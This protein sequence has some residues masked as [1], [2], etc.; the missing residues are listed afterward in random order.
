MEMMLPVGA[1]AGELPAW[2]LVVEGMPDFL[3]N[4]LQR[5]FASGRVQREGRPLA[6]VDKVRGGDTVVVDV[7]EGSLPNI[8][9]KA[10][11][12]SIVLE[13]ER[14]L[15]VDKPAGLSMLPGLG[16]E[17]ITLFE[18]VWHHLRPS[19]V[20][21]RIV[22]RIDKG[23]SGLVLFAKD[24]A[25]QS[26]LCAQF[27]N[28]Q[29]KKTYWALVDGNL[30]ADEGQ[31]DAPLAPHPRRP[32]QMTV[33]KTKGKAARTLW[34]VTERFGH[35]TQL[36]LEPLTGRTHQLRVHLASLGHPLAVDP[37]YGSETPVMLSGVKKGYR[38]KGEGKSERPL[39]DR[40]PLHAAKLAFR[41]PMRGHWV[42]VEAPLPKDLDVAI[43]QLTRWDPPGARP[44][45][46]AGR[47]APK[48]TPPPRTTV[49][50]VTAP[51]ATPARDGAIVARVRATRVPREVPTSRA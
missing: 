14:F 30:A 26:H 12:L 17:T 20:R 21:P 11:P 27:Q 15:V 48:A 4:F 41:H 46:R 9:P 43:K 16:F 3:E 19:G 35:Y 28:R 31:V 25:T 1:D 7:P 37:M 44:T 13:E 8:A 10:H 32:E 47:A 22:N 45:A 36:E 50:R 18:A 33:D 38:G 51:R 23:T 34:K 39:L 40:T 24:R 29:V 2:E 49:T 42:E 5:L 6:P